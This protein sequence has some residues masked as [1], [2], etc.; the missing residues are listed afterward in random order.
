MPKIELEIPDYSEREGL[1]Y[2]W[3]YSYTISTDLQDDAVVISANK[4]G[5][6]S[7]A[8]QI[9]TLANAPYDGAHF[10]YDEFGCLEENSIELIISRI[11][12]E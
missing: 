7:L 11:D 10:H 1:K 12:E 4:A 2:S 3:E 6:I 5:L 9:L 8:K